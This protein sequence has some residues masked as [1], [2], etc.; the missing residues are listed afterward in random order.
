MN[1]TILD[2]YTKYSHATFPGCYADYLKSLPTSDI[3][4]IGYLIRKSVIDAHALEI[5]NTQT[6]KDL[7]YG[8]MTKVPWYRCREDDVF[9]TT[10][11]MLSELFRRDPRG[12][13]LE[14]TEE[15]SLIVSCR[16]VAILVASMLKTRGIPAR[17]R[18][19]FAPY[20]EYEDMKGCSWDHWITQY[21][22]IVESRWISIDVDVSIEPY[23]KFD[24]YDLPKDLFD[25]S[26]DAWLRV[27]SGKVNPGYFQNSGG[28]QG[29]VVIAWELFY[30]FHCLMNNEPIYTNTV[31]MAFLKV[32]PTIK[33]NDLR[34]I[35]NLARLL[36]NPDENFEKLVRI[37][38]SNRK[39]RIIHG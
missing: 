32:F 2:Y 11:S 8:D 35:D 14:C 7:R 25:F 23:I 17:V 30:D 36:Q 22:N 28:T 13:T 38:N 19:G 33:E 24:P 20:F 3:E 12:L 31:D 4:K 27:R 18:S 26:A 10:S 21:W 34:E 9:T 5:G 16:N 39:F 15:N 37:F 6:N 1:Q 29:L